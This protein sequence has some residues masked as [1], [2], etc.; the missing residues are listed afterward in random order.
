VR[1]GDLECAIAIEGSGG[2]GQD[3]AVVVPRANDVIIALADGSGGSANGGAAAQ[4]VIDTA[5]RRPEACVDVTSLLYELDDPER[6]Q[7]GETT[8]V[9][10]IASST[11]VTGAS[12][13]DSGAW[14]IDHDSIIDLTESQRR[15]PFLGAGCTPVEF[16]N[17]FPFGSTLLVAS[18][19]LWS[20]TKPRDIARVASGQ[21][22]ELAAS[23][24]VDLARLPS[25]ALQD[26]ISIVLCRRA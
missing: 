8:A 26:D 3:R 4:S 9:I 7:H 10:L 2:S 14:L 5:M 12:V 18:D 20:Y 17:P 11:L 6:V 19:G 22:L 23:A 13:G 16:S 15:K 21:R 24:L 25:G 1:Y